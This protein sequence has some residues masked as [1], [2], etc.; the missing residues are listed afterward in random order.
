MTVFGRRGFG[1]QNF[2]QRYHAV[3]VAAADKTDTKALEAGGGWEPCCAAL[4]SALRKDSMPR[5]CGR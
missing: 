2:S 3:P 4:V 5:L 1:Q